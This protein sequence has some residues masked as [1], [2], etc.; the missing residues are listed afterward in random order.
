MVTELFQQAGDR[1]FVF[2]RSEATGAVDQSATGLQRLKC[3]L[4]QFRSNEIIA[5]N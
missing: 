3:G 5:P 4:D 1:G 2:F